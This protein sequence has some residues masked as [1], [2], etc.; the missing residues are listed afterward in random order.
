MSVATSTRPM[1]DAHIHAYVDGQLKREREQRLQALLGER[2]EKYEQIKEYQ[3]INLRLQEAL[4]FLLEEELPPAISNLLNKNK[5]LRKEG[6]SSAGKEKRISHAQ[7]S[8][9]SGGKE[10][11]IDLEPVQIAEKRP[12][13]RFRFLLSFVTIALILGF[14][15]G[16]ALR[17]N[18]QLSSEMMVMQINNALT[19]HRL[20]ADSASHA[21]DYAAQE[22]GALKKKFK[23]M[24][25]QRLNVPALK[26]FKLALLGGRVLPL[27]PGETAGYLLYKDQ[28]QKTSV[29]VYINR[30]PNAISSS[31]PFCELTSGK[32]D[33]RESVCLWQRDGLNYVIVSK[34]PVQDLRP[35][36]KEVQRQIRPVG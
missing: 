26:S 25:G 33:N 12:Q 18:V 9:D 24:F 30:I 35:I 34:I 23:Q 31:K 36:A 22:N 19:A 6:G 10:I 29:S 16:W 7:Q 13:R 3:A 17:Q 1:S 15:S 4:A 21:V 5:T 27:G 32:V 28:K 14:V 8:P 11:N 2:P 20:Y